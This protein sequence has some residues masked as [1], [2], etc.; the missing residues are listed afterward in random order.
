MKQKT[1]DVLIFFLGIFIG[2]GLI[3][4]MFN[5][6]VK[7]N[8]EVYGIEL[9]NVEPAKCYGGFDNT[10]CPVPRDV[11]CSFDGNAPIWLIAAFS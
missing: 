5:V 1:K 3:I 4:V 8:C 2:I 6:K 7:A 10:F 11:K 9:K